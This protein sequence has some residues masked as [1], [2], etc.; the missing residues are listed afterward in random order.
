MFIILLKLC[1]LVLLIFIL[2]LF[3]NFICR[4]YINEVILLWNW[5]L[6]IYV[7]DTIWFLLLNF[8][9]F[10][11]TNSLVF[12]QVF[13]GIGFFLWFQV[14]KFKERFVLDSLIPYI[15]KSI[16]IRPYTPFEGKFFIFEG[17]IVLLFMVIGLYSKLLFII[18]FDSFDL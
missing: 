1:V 8:I 18:A 15:E 17:F 5:L 9:I 6:L 13:Y 14:L 2:L 12:F 16:E 10:I 4:M 11:F 7:F 3:R